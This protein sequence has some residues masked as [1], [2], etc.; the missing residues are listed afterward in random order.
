MTPEQQMQMMQQQ[1]A[2][3]TDIVNQTTGGALGGMDVA[4][5]GG[6]QPPAAAREM[7]KGSA[8]NPTE[9]LA[10]QAH[11]RAQRMVGGAAV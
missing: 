7:G 5:S 10:Q 3:L 1:I 2:M 11:A 6:A 8:G 9:E 4:P